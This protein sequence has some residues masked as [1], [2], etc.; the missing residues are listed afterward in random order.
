LVETLKVLHLKL[1]NISAAHNDHHTSLILR[2]SWVQSILLQLV[3]N[4]SAMKCSITIMTVAFFHWFPMSWKLRI[5]YLYNFVR[6]KVLQI[7]ERPGFQ[8][9]NL[10]INMYVLLEQNHLIYH[11]KKIMWVSWI[12]LWFYRPPVGSSYCTLN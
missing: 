12:F 9:D 10:A 4:I 6:L 2:G 8:G 1:I 5:S 7:V 11:F 3:L